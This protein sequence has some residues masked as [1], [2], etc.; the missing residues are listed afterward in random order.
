MLE[1][2]INNIMKKIKALILVLLVVFFLTGCSHQS[3][4]QTQSTNVLDYQIYKND[5]YGFEFQQPPKWEVDKE[6]TSSN[7]IVFVDKK[8]G[9]GE[10]REAI[11]FESNNKNLSLDQ[12]VNELVKEFDYDEQQINRDY[13]IKIGGE[14]NARIETN[15]FGIILYVFLHKETIFYIETQNNF[16]TEDVLKTFKFTD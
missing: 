2:L 16:F 3:V 6:R 13:S 1:I 14:K 4:D 10:D 15:E 12:I 11:N 9:A 8:I 5:K 7:T